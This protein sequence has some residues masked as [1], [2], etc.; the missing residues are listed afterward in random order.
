MNTNLLARGGS[1]DPLPQTSHSEHR[2]VDEEEDQQCPL[3]SPSFECLVE[4]ELVW[5]CSSITIGAIQ[6]AMCTRMWQ[7]DLSYP[8]HHSALGSR[9]Q[10]PFSW[11]AR[12]EYSDISWQQHELIQ[13]MLSSLLFLT[14]LQWKPTS[15]LC[16]QCHPQDL[17]H[18]WWQTS[19]AL[20][21]F[22]AVWCCPDSRKFCCFKSLA[23]PSDKM[24][25]S[26]S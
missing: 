18:D 8:N 5:F 12:W 2:F 1:P 6:M 14:S 3:L 11:C 17:C 4:Y 9:S 20:Y 22:Q 16:F 7:W 15:S 21:F 19:S 25:T 26:W 23:A 13:W 24:T 10:P